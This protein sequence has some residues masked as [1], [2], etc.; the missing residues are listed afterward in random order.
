MI[1]FK[2]ISKGIDFFRVITPICT[3]HKKN[4]NDLTDLSEVVFSRVL[5][6]YSDPPAGHSYSISLYRWFHSNPFDLEKQ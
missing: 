2:S 6:K 1:A 5:A 3:S 4:I